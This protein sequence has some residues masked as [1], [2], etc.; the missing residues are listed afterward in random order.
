MPLTVREL[1]D[2]LD[3]LCAQ[4][5]GDLPVLAWHQGVYDEVPVT[6]VEVVQTREARMQKGAPSWVLLR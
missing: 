1:H 6:E 2:T 5:S 3:I 4:G